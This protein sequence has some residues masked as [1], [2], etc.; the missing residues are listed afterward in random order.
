MESAGKTV[1][2]L[3]IFAGATG[4]LVTLWFY[5]T[6]AGL[7]DSMRGSAISQVRSVEEIL[8]DAE[9]VVAATEGGA[10]AF[11]SFAGNSS[12]TLG[13]SAEMLDGMGS[14]VGSLAD[15]LALIPLMPGDAVAGL[16]RTAGDMRES[17]ANLAQAGELAA[18]MQG[19]AAEASASLARIGE[20]MR[21]AGE[22]LADTER[23]IG[24]MHSTA[25]SALLLWSI[26][27]VAVFGINMLSFYGQLR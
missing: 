5:L 22:G 18:R 8:A 24:E 21:D 4:I 16:R 13:S 1:P 20:E 23:E 14:A 6:L 10:G 7:L 19:S 9:D 25:K 26:L 2:Y 15:G 27:L 17:A 3:G 11:S 12:E